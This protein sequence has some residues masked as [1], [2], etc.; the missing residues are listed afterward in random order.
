MA[1]KI[2][3]R[4][5]MLALIALVSCA[6]WFIVSRLSN[7]SGSRADSLSGFAKPTG[8]AQLVSV[9]PL[10]EETGEMC[11]YPEAHVEDVSADVP[12]SSEADPSL[13][14]DLRGQEDL[15]PAAQPSPADTPKTT[16]ADR[17]PERIIKDPYPSFSAVAVEPNS[18]MVVLTD[19][20][21]FNVLQYDRRDNTPASAK[22]T[23]LPSGWSV[24][25]RPKRR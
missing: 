11:Q 15:K 19:E 20:N 24:E 10:P 4:S 5:A 1:R 8:S 7:P 6:G 3:R 18:N 23:E 12:V 22:F 2:A 14:A 21:L 25:P 16:N 17:A 13:V 9:Q